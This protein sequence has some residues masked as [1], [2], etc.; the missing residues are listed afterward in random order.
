MMHWLRASALGAGLLLLA[1]DKPHERIEH[2]VRLQQSGEAKLGAIAPG[3]GLWGIDGGGPF[4]LEKLRKQPSPATL[5]IT[6][7]AS[8]CP[9]CRLGLPRLKAL[10][11]KHPELRLVLVDLDR[12]AADARA[13]VTE[14]GLKTDVPVLHD[15]FEFAAKLYGAAGESK[16][17]LPKTVLVDLRGRVRAI[18]GIEGEDLETVIEADLAEVAR[19]AEEPPVRPASTQ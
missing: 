4:V 14:V 16:T 15:K 1:A 8:W 7:G 2:T 11:E 13:W 6:F 3:F 12:N 5:L 17:S 10:A 19:A 18:Y 9:P